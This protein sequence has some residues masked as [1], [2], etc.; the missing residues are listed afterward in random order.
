[1]EFRHARYSMESRAFATVA[2]V[3]EVKWS[4]L[5]QAEGL[6]QAFWHYLARSAREG[7]ASARLPDSAQLHC[8]WSGLCQYAELAQRHELLAPQ[9]RSTSEFAAQGPKS[10]R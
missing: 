8:E 4:R 3:V 2:S 6:L 10:A 1:V 7:R 9:S 5:S